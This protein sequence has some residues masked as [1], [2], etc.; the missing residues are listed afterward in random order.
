[1]TELSPQEKIIEAVIICIE[2]FGLENTTTRKIAE[3]AGTN[4][5]AINYYFRSKDDLITQSLSATLLHMEED[6]QEILQDE[7]KT[8]TQ[9]LREWV[10]YLLDGAKIYPRVL[11]A[12]MYPPLV[13][14]CLDTPSTASFRKMLN[15]LTERAIHAYPQHNP[16]ELRITLI[17]IVSAVIFKAMS[18]EFFPEIETLT[19]NELA[20]RYLDL[21]TGVVSP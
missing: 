1:M 16:D 2:K 17:Q 18:T 3:E 21:F 5:A 9:V 8:F 19:T 4:I 7:T 11:V 10:I 15:D 20:D 13:E 6:L 12:H 14:K